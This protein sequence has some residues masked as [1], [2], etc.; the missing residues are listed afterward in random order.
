MAGNRAHG[1]LRGNASGRNGAGKPSPWYCEGCKKEH[2][3]QTSRT[4]L[5]GSDYCDK[6]YYAIKEAQFAAQSALRIQPALI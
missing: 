5:E 4:L 1:F 3:G 2:V 6:T